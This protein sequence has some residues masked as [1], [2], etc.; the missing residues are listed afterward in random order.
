MRT[1]KRGAGKEN[2]EFELDYVCKEVMSKER[3]KVCSMQ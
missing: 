3:S 1:Y 2:A